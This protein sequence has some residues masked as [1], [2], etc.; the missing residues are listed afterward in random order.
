MGSEEKCAALGTG[1]NGEGM[2]DLVVDTGVTVG[3]RVGHGDGGGW[4]LEGRHRGG[5]TTEEGGGDVGGGRGI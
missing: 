2:T 5:T 3:E 4:L 1:T